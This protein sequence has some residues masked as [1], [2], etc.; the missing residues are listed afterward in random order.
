MTWDDNAKRYRSGCISHSGVFCLFI[1]LSFLSCLVSF[2]HCFYAL[3]CSCSKC[4]SVSNAY[5]RKLKHWK[6]KKHSDIHRSTYGG[7]RCNI[8][9][10]LP[11]VPKKINNNNLE[12][13]VVRTRIAEVYS[14]LSMLLTNDVTSNFH[15]LS[16]PHADRA[17][18]TFLAASTREP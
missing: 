8:F 11:R 18:Q 17:T 10:Y 3:P 5:L 7:G 9:F 6:C 2:P 16:V 13:I 1:Y 4:L 15:T 14:N 12:F